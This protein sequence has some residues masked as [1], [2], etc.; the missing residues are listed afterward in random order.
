MR[1]PTL[2]PEIINIIKERGYKLRNGKISFLER[3]HMIEITLKNNE[4]SV[5]ICS[6]PNREVI[7]LSTCRYKPKMS[8]T[9]KEDLIDDF[10]DIL[11]EYEEYIEP[12]SHEFKGIEEVTYIS[13]KVKYN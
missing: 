2:L 4:H 12:T 5:M 13:S 3:F 1:I 8:M 9:D 11:T 7:K 6:L 10:N